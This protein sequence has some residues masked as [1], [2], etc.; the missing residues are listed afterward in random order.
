MVLSPA[1]SS[2][3]ETM[4]LFNQHGGENYDGEPVSQTSHMVQCAM[5]ALEN[6]S[7]APLVLGAPLHDVGHLLKHRQPT[8]QM[9]AY[10]VI[11]HEAV[12]AAYLRSQGFGQRVCSVVEQHVA[13]KRY[14]V[15]ADAGYKSKLSAA[16]LQ[17][18]AWQGGAMSVE[19]C[20]AFERHRFFHDIIKVR[21]WDEEAKSTTA[22]VLPLSWF[23]K[24]IIEHLKYAVV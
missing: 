4:Q 13:A 18:L 21:R 22:A 5:L 12:G 9:G 8:A 14:L 7:D 3:A 24:L 20:T 16:S 19:E 23:E 15:A 2:T 1:E 17:T 6:L 10:G 11:N